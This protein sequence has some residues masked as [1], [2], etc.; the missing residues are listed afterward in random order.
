MS[1]NEL[2]FSSSYSSNLKCT[3]NF[4][5]TF[6]KDIFN[7][8]YIIIIIILYLIKIVVRSYEAILHLV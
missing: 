1:R 7:I 6:N 5:F 3:E 4:N 2:V 8:S